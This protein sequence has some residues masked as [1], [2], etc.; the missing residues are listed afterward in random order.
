MRRGEQVGGA[1]AVGLEELGVVPGG[2]PARHVVDDIGAFGGLAERVQGVEIAADQADAARG[3]A[4][5]LARGADQ[6]G[7]RVPA[8]QQC[9]DE[10]AADEAGAAGDERLHSGRSYIRSVLYTTKPILE[11]PRFMAGLSSRIQPPSPQ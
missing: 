10:V 7:D 11:R 9:V 5:G 4:G 3:E 1:F 6:R 8:L 2:D